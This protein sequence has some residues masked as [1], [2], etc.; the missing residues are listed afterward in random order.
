MLNLTS[1]NFGIESDHPFLTWETGERSTSADIRDKDFFGGRA[2]RLSCSAGRSDLVSSTAPEPLTAK[3]VG[4]P[5]E[6]REGRGGGMEV[7]LLSA[8]LDA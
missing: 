3:V 8:G 5:R 7:E 2:G 1:V 4:R 6:L